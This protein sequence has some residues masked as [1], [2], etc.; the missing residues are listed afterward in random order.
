MDILYS[1]NEKFVCHLAAAL[2]SVCENNRAADTITFHIFSCGIIRESQQQLTSLAHSYGREIAFYELGDMHTHIN[3]TIDTKGFNSIVLA[4]L[5]TGSYL[6][7]S[8]ER[9]IY[10]DCDTIVIDDITPFWNTEMGDC[11][12]ACVPEPVITKSR[13][14]L[15]GMAPSDDYYNAGVLLFDLNA[16]RREN[17]EQRV[18]SYYIEHY[19]SIVA[20]DQDALNAC[21]KGRIRTVAP[22]YNYA[23]YNLYY[24]YR[25]LKRLSGDAPYV[26]REVW[27]DSRRNPAIIHYLGE[28]RPWRAGNTHPYTDRYEQYLSMTPWRD[29]P[30]ERGW[31]LYFF[32]F[33]IFNFCTKPFPWLRYRIIDSLIPAF[34]RHRAKKLRQERKAEKK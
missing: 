29:T 21:F 27:E 25:L 23:S 8:V 16:W 22:K 28:E 3:A 33:R 18:L 12:L 34:M 2:C 5:F 1:A 6:P 7:E 31:R 15:L 11:V 17:C 19:K 14:G 9:V 32:C 30:K 10:L 24:N 26:S 20:Q 4:R 13:R